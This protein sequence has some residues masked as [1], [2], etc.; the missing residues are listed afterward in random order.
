MVQNVVVLGMQW[1]DEG[2]GKIVDLLTSKAKYVVRYQG[3]HNAGHTI[4]VN[5]KKISL[6]LVPSG[7][8]HDHVIN[9]IASGVVLSP[10]F[11]IKELDILKKINIS[12][13][14]RILISE[15]CSLILPYHI[16]IDQAREV[17]AKNF[18]DAMVIGTTGC[19]IGPAYEDKVA[20][21]AIRISDLYNQQ[22]F[23]DKLKYVS[24][25]YNF[26]LTNYYHTKSI[27]YKN[28][29]DDIM[30]TADILMDMVT[31]VPNLLEKARKKQDRVIFE[32]S[33]GSLLDVDHGTYPYVTSAHT[34]AGGVGLGVGVG[35][36]YIDY[37]L[38]IVKAYST[39]VGC[40]PFPTELSNKTKQAH[41]LSTK[42]NEFG[43][44][45]GRRRRTGWFD[46]VL[47]RYAIK[48]N[49]IMSCCLTK[50]DVLDGLEEIKICVSYQ[51]PNGKIIYDFPY[52]LEQFQ[53]IIPIYEVL[54]GWS[55]NTKDITRFDQL[56][57][58]A[59]NYIKRIE[60]IIGI[61]INMIS[62]GSD[63]SMIINL[64]SL[65]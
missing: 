59:R 9:I 11:L 30:S 63:R 37:I 61:P 6:H 16:A 40:G 20:R 23:K 34:I 44:T 14:N 54:P 31:N 52:F 21:R 4:D 25:Y 48:I 26:Q 62:T 64:H 3:G 2:K 60:E 18:N 17:H 15:S 53:N 12:T 58:T 51:M 43:S 41:W 38:G 1:G 39:R 7:I 33:Q 57:K 24:D 49:S 65:F 29:I 35:P 10:I 42:G 36:N 8:L 47:V 13:H 55:G 45:T 50:I 5:N 46:A 28:V 22:K 27:N 32:G 56:P 19:G